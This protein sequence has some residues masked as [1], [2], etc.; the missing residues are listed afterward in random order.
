MSQYISKDGK[1]GKERNAEYERL[2]RSKN[3]ERYREIAHQSYWRNPERSRLLKRQ[4]N[5]RVRLKVLEYYGNGRL[6]CVICGESRLAC[7]SIDHIN[8]N[9]STHRQQIGSGTPL[10]YWLIRNNYPNGYQTLCMNCQFI[11]RAF[12]RECPGRPVASG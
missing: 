12:N 9:G 7:L 6:A 1:T 3:P 8:S 5:E 11:K 2:W 10:Y 4:R